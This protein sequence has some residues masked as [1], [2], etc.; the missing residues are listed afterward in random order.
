M[1]TREASGAIQYDEVAEYTLPPLLTTADGAA[2]A[3]A[4]AWYSQR[5]AEGQELVGEQ[6]MGVSPPLQLPPSSGI[7]VRYETVAEQP[8]LGGAASQRDVAMIYEHA[9]SGT[10]ATVN[11]LLFL[12]SAPAGTAGHRLICGLNFDGNHAIFPDPSIGISEELHNLSTPASAAAAGSSHCVASLLLSDEDVAAIQDPGAIGHACP[13]HG[14]ETV[15]AGRDGRPVG[16]VRRG[17][18]TGGAGCPIT[19]WTPD[20]EFSAW[21]YLENAAAVEGAELAVQTE[22]G[23]W[24]R[25]ICAP[26]SLEEE[27]GHS[28]GRWGVADAIGRGCGIATVWSVSIDPATPHAMPWTELANSVVLGWVNSTAISTQRP[29]PPQSRSCSPRPVLRRAAGQLASGPGA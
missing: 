19:P 23:H 18:I 27:R 3:S 24:V 13:I 11:L 22:E 1:A 16:F 7:T 25:A 28:A 9:A 5:R 20:N 17:R 15:Y 8:A 6:M 21:V 26:P 14:G 10:A 4:D 2:V 29:A 12:P